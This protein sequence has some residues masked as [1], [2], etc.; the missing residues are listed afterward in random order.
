MTINWYPGHM[1]KANKELRKIL[2]GTR[3]LIEVL[4]ARIPAASSNPSLAELGT[5][6]PR[7]KILNKADLA[8]PDLTS[9]WQRHFNAE[10]NSRCLVSEL[11]EPLT[12]QDIIRTASQLIT[13]GPEPSASNSGQ[14]IIV[15]I[16]NVGKSTLMNSLAG[17][18]LANTGNEPA[19]TKGQQRIRLNDD[20]FLVD[21]PGLLWPRL[22][23]QNAAY[24]LAMTGTIRNTAIDLEDIAWHAAEFLLNE[25]HQAL[26]AR[27]QL[28][29]SIQD[30][31]G[32][33]SH[34]AALR[35]AK[36]RGGGIDWHKTSELLLNDFRSGKL[37]RITLEAP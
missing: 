23:D 33:L 9:A 7:I 5:D 35:G 34:I 37:G 29:A 19:V 18:K 21:T 13:D 22:D 26:Q 17:R 8:D 3:I 27:Y 11:S 20:W 16:P 6:I 10:P 28:P 12:E 2:P 25:H 15:G 30:A 31:E 1:H 32:C 14:I 4:D 36:G 24:K